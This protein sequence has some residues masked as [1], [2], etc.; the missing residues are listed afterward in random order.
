MPGYPVVP[1]IFVAAVIY[2]VGNALISDP[3]WTA[4]TFAI[5]LAGVPVYFA[6]F[7]KK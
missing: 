5:V 3:V 2:L 4:V 1:A 7:A 6:A